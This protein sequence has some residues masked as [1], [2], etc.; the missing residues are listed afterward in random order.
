MRIIEENLKTPQYYVSSAPSQEEWLKA[1]EVV[2]ESRGNLPIYMLPIY[3]YTS[4]ITYY[5][6]ECNN[7]P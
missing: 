6:N 3:L 4:Q 7:S 1:A 2:R 5:S